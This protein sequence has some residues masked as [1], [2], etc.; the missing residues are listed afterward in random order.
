MAMLG[1]SLLA[2]SQVSCLQRTRLRYGIFHT[3]GTL[4]LCLLFVRQHCLKHL[5]RLLFL[6]GSLH[7][8]RKSNVVLI[9]CCSPTATGKGKGCSLYCMWAVKPLCETLSG[10]ELV[11]CIKHL[12]SVCGSM[13]KHFQLGCL[14][15]LRNTWAQAWRVCRQQ[16]LI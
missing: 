4:C 7:Y 1:L 6:L 10:A 15:A 13:L 16:A 9:P 5:P 14:K 12:M 2:N 11:S 8:M 3:T